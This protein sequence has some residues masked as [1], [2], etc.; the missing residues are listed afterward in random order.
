MT[1]IRR[2][3]LDELRWGDWTITEDAELGLRVFASGR[4]AAYVPESHGRG[5]MPDRFIDYKKQR[6]RWAY[7]AMQIMKHHAPML[8]LGA[9]TELTRGQRYHFLAGWLPWCADGLNLFFTAGALVW[10]AAMLLVPTQALP[11]AM[12]FALPPMLL[13]FSKLAK[14][15]YVYRRHIR[16]PLGTSIGAAVAGLALSHT[17]GKAVIYGLV[18]RTI[19]FFRTPKLSG[20]GGLLQAIA[21]S[22][23]E[24]Y[25]LILLWGAAAGL[26]LV[27]VMDTGDAYAWLAML[28]LQSLPYLAAVVMSGLAVLPPR[29]DRLTL[30]EP[31]G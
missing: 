6:F 31:V 28:L 23:E 1:M 5:L 27:H 26:M 18:T 21:E 30:A 16:V 29:E 11:P 3:V 24:L 7:G 14:I 12:V 17:I 9:R 2:Q 15:L 10:T 22:R 19:P 8:F 25:M 13:F 20:H 4:S